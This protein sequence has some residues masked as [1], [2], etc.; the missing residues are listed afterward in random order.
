MLLHPDAVRLWLLEAA[1]VQAAA[2]GC[3]HCRGVAGR[4]VEAA[5]M[6]CAALLAL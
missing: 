4:V 2:W 3:R 1:M 6:Q 5:E